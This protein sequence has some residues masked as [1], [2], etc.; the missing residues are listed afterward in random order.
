[1]L[2]VGLIILVIMTITGLSAMR[3]AALEERMAGNLKDKSDSLQAAEAALQAALTAIQ[4][5]PQGLRTAPFGNATISSGCRVI[6]ADSAS[7]CTLQGDIP[8]DWLDT[9]K[10]I[11]SGA[12]YKEYANTRLG[13]PGATVDKGDGTEEETDAWA[14]P[15]ITVQF[16]YA[17]ADLT[18]DA[19]GE[20]RGISYY[21]VSAIATGPSGES[22]SI[23]QTTIPTVYAW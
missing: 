10:P 19:Q 9:K 4:K 1:M 20:Q 8:E 3:G 5:S 17:P 2:F 6:D 23:L 16:R 7:T 15:R 13:P 12:Q 21:T 18:F 22:R 11:T 14:Q